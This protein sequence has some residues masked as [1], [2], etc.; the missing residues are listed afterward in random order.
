MAEDGERDWFDG[1]EDERDG[2]ESFIEDGL[3]QITLAH[4]KAPIILAIVYVIF[5]SCVSLKFYAIHERRKAEWAKKGKKARKAVR[6]ADAVRRFSESFLD[7]TDHVKPGHVV[8]AH[9][10]EEAKKLRL[11]RL[12]RSVREK[13]L[14]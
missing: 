10:D 6:K 4:M 8:D 3:R 9:R 12:W 13:K 2:V 5:V 11:K 14:V 1:A 7:L